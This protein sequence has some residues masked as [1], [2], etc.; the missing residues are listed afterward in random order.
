MW[1]VMFSEEMTFKLWADVLSGS[2]WVGGGEFCN[3]RRGTSPVVQWLRLCAPNV[4]RPGS[5]SGQ[6]ARSHMP[7]VNKSPMVK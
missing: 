3:K 6:G 5:I 4:G 7:Q 1:H 2:W